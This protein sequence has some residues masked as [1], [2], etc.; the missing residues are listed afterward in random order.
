MDTFLEGSV[1]ILHPSTLPTR[2]VGSTQ[3][4]PG[5]WEAS[6]DKSLALPGHPLLLRRLLASALFYSLWRIPCEWEG[7]GLEEVQPLIS[8]EDRGGMHPGRERKLPAPSVSNIISSSGGDALCAAPQGDH[9]LHRAT[10]R[11][12]CGPCD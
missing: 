5:R 12:K 10:E 11:W 6:V 8:A 1:G 9:R 7:E 2:Q 3:C 4:C